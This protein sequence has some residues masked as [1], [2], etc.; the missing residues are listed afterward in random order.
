MVPNL[1][2]VDVQIFKNEQQSHHWSRQT[3]TNF[4]QV[5]DQNLGR[6]LWLHERVEFSW[7]D[8][9]F[10]T[11]PS[12]RHQNQRKL[13]GYK[14]RNYPCQQEGEE[15]FYYDRFPN[16]EC[17]ESSLQRKEQKIAILFD[18]VHSWDRKPSRKRLQSE[19]GAAFPY[20]KDHA[21]RTEMAD[22]LQNPFWWDHQRCWCFCLTLHKV[23][24]QNTQ[25]DKFHIYQTLWEKSAFFDSYRATVQLEYQT[26][27]FSER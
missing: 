9:Y 25:I 21:T 23:R 22:L 15:Q 8:C 26:D 5:Y 20:L 3:Q 6:T 24:L 1:H 10:R 19:V 4:Y 16:A 11:L 17:L 18:S 2:C 13:R 14:I 7:Y 12:L 27:H